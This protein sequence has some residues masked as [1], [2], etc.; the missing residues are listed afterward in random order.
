MPTPT[1]PGGHPVDAVKWCVQVLFVY[2]LHQMLVVIVLP[3]GPVVQAAAIEPKQPALTGDRYPFVADVY[4]P[5]F[6]VNR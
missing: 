5:A 1:Q 4:S 6:L 2:Q 3:F